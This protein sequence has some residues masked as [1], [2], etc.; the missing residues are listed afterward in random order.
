VRRSRSWPTIEGH[1][2][3]SA[4]QASASYSTVFPSTENPLSDGGKWVQG[5]TVGLDWQNTRSVPGLEY[6]SGVN[7]YWN[8]D[9]SISHLTGFAANH[10]A[11]ATYFKDA[12]YSP[13]DSHECEL[14]LRFDITAHNARGYEIQFPFG[15]GIEIVKWNG[16]AG[17]Y[18]VI[19][20]NGTGA[21]P[22]TLVTGD[23]LRAEMV[24]SVIT[25]KK[26][27]ATCF[28]VTDTAWT[29][30]QPGIGNFVRPGSGYDLARC[31]WT[32]YSAGDL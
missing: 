17:D 11:Q 16:P 25:V 29:S 5:G 26:N 18:T 21:G 10:Y 20:T 9:D 30:G 24:G 7:A 2:G 23:V 22:G 32:A 15:G 4:G 8:Y 6:A 13:A 28:S 3:I 27:G 12:G 14:L 19:T 31:G 1:C